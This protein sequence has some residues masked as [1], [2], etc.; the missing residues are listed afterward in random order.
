MQRII[1]IIIM[2]MVPLQTA[3][4][5]AV[6]L[7]GHM[8]GEGLARIMH[9]HEHAHQNE[10][11]THDDISA[12]AS[13]DDKSSHEDEHH[14]PHCHPVFNSVLAESCLTVGVDLTNTAILQAPV[15]FYSHTPP[16]FD[17]PPLARA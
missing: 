13:A 7:H 5:A 15:S 17:R 1:A 14:D 6:S 16:L 8:S 9:V 4:S 10:A 3:W 11:H 2:F 12:S